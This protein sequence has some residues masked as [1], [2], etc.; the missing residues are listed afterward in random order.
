MSSAICLSLR[1]LVNFL[2][3]IKL[4]EIKEQFYKIAKFPGV[5]MV[6]DCT[7]IPICS[8]GGDTSELY[9]NRKNWMSLNVQL[10]AGPQLQIFDVV[11]RWPGSAHDSRIFENSRAWNIITQG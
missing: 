6:I 3:T 8:P 11:A 10:I 7:N 9:R 1:T 2:S 5:T 4:Q